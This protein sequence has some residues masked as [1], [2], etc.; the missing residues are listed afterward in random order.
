MDLSLMG[1]LP[2]GDDAHPVSSIAA[3]GQGSSV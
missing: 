3:A 2:H 1:F